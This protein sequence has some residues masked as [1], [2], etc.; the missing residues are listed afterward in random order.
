M[1]DLKKILH[2][3]LYFVSK[4][5]KNRFSGNLLGKIWL[6]INPLLQIAMYSFV[7]S[8]VLKIKIIYN[9]SDIHFIPFLLTGLFPWLAF[10]EAVSRSSYVIFENGEI[11]K[12]IFFPLESLIIG[13]VFSS[14]IIN[15][16]AFFI[17]IIPYNIYEIFYKNGSFNFSI[18]I[19]PFIIFFQ[20]VAAAGIGF[21]ISALTTYIK[22]L[23]QL[24]GIFIQVWFYA[25]PIIYPISM[26]PENVAVIF[27]LN[28]FYGFLEM[29][30][31]VIFDHTFRLGLFSAWSIIFSCFVFL[32]GIYLFKKLKTGFADVL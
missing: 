1:N 20:A 10:Q 13:T 31:S 9:S 27:K 22:D 30:R 21:G 7:F 28:P 6:F 24:V 8:Y 15:F 25:T 2:F 18:F 16:I 32:S 17:F 14:F 29:Y 12:K 19:V 5:F 11:V 23:I 4:D 3:S 26:I